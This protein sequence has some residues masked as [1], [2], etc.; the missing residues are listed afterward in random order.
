MTTPEQQLALARRAQRLVADPRVTGALLGAG[1]AI[2]AILDGGMRDQ[3]TLGG[4]QDLA[5]GPQRTSGGTVT[6]PGWSE[7]DLA[8]WYTERRLDPIRELLRKD[9]HRYQPPSA[10]RVCHAPMARKGQCGRSSSRSTML[11]DWTTGQRQW[12]EACT[13]HID[14]WT[15]FTTEHAR[16]KPDI[17]PSPTRTPA[18]HSPATSPKSTG[19]SS[20][21]NLTPSGNQDPNANPPR[22]AHQHCGS[23]RANLLYRRKAPVP[24]GPR[25]AAACDSPS[26]PTSTGS[27][28]SHLETTARRTA[29]PGLGTAAQFA[30]RASSQCAVS[31]PGMLVTTTSTW[32]CR[33]FHRAQP[34][35]TNHR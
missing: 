18:A 25:H 22:A 10:R 13:R 21:V 28:S 8:A 29:V 16:G 23:P 33:D 6:V 14:W 12:C 20:G 26:S 34:K 15:T 5:L 17:V 19:P 32:F 2:A 27:N 4:I 7:Q 31:D 35:T 9:I 11:T 30:T 3:V 1:L 24:D